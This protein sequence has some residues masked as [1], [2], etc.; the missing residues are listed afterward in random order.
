M[1]PIFNR[2][3]VFSSCFDSYVVVVINILD[4]STLHPIFSAEVGASSMIVYPFVVDSEFDFFSV[5][6]HE[7]NPRN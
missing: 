3:H 5:F 4:S 2:D 7:N 6:S 1:I